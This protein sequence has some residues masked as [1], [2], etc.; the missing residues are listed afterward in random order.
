M[1]LGARRW[2]LEQWLSRTAAMAQA[3]LTEDGS[4]A[5]EWSN[6]VLSGG[7]TLEGVRV[8]FKVS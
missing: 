4:H 5:L 2:F 6:A 1:R 7:L 8:D 3:K